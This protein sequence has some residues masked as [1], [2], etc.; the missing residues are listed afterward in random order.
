MAV[1]EALGIAAMGKISGSMPGNNQTLKQNLVTRA[2][3]KKGLT[4]GSC[5]KQPLE[6][7]R[8]LG[9]PMQ[10]VSSWNCHERQP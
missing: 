5:L 3:V 7:V 6:A 4:R 9:D 10:A 2:M 8:L 1:M